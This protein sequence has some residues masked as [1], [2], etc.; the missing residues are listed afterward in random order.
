M[1]APFS[2]Y[3]TKNVL[4]HVGPDG[5]PYRDEATANTDAQDRNDRAARLGIKTRYLVGTAKNKETP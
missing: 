5:K 3:T 4:A 2:I 1:P